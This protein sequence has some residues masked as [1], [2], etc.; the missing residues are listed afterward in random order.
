[1]VEIEI[2]RLGEHH[3]GDDR[4]AD[5]ADHLGRQVGPGVAPAQPAEGGVDERDDRVEMCPRDR[6]EHQ[7]D[8]E[9]PGCGGRR[10]LEELEPDVARRQ[11]WAAMPEPTTMAARNALPRNSA[12][13]RRHR[14]VSLTTCPSV[15]VRR[16]GSAAGRRAGR[17]GVIPA[18]RAPSTASG[19]QHGASTA[20]AGLR[21]GV[22][23]H[24]VDLPWRTVGVADPDLVLDGV[25]AGRRSST[26]GSRPSPRAGGWRPDL[27]GRLDLDAE[28][29]ERA[30]RRRGP[31][32]PRSISTSLSGGSAM[33]KLA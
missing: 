19:M 2:G 33:A 30:R 26:S 17:P 9:E 22:G 15:P 20:E 32:R 6:P 8:G 14:A 5:A 25:A 10:V 16:A 29:V 7:D 12:S 18:P 24:G 23:Q 1:M 31:R 27:L 4:P 13:S 3:V 28:V 21:R 11:L